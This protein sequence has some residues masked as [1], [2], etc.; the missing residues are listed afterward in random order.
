MDNSV[1]IIGIDGAGW[2]LLKPWIKEGELPT[3]KKLADNGII[4]DLRTTIPPLS[5]SAWT[6]LFTGKNPG[7]HGIY[8]YMTESGKLVNSKL[9]KSEKI[10]QTLSSHGKRCCIVNVPMTF[11]VEE[12]NGYMI[13]GFLTPPDEDVYT[14]PSSLMSLLK[15]NN[16]KVR[17]EFL[18][19]EK[20]VSDKKYKFLAELYD[21]LEKRYLTLKQLMNKEWDFFVLVFEETGPLQYLFWDKKDVMLKFFKKVDSYINELIKIYS[22]NNRRTC[23][24]IVSDHGFNEAPKRCFNMRAWMDN[25]G[26]LKDKRSSLQKVIPKVYRKINKIPFSKLIFNFDKPK[27]IRESFQRKI[28]ES[29]PIYYRYPGIFIDNKELNDKEYGELRNNIITQL[30]NIQDPVTKELIFQIVEKREAVYHGNSLKFAPDIVAIPKH[31]YAVMFSF[32][33]NKPFEDMKLYHP[34]RHFSDMYGIFL[35][36][37]DDIRKSSFREVSIID[38][39]PTVLHI[40]GVPISKDADGK[41]LREIFKENSDLLN[42][43]IVFA[44][45]DAMLNEKNKIKDSLKNIKI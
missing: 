5:C 39:Y 1:L 32:E 18:P 38:I 12:I 36:F 11:P 21:V 24:F 17:Y 7:K 3:L 20:D 16:Y 10:W 15:K 29:S 42:K 28:A 40:L 8:E 34:G 37:G 27:E 9:I 14:Y 45:E 44:Q 26:I 19:D 33:S 4:A 31:N 22:A 13:A 6:S 2:N 43:E 25:S 23:I 35:A 41:V 30:R